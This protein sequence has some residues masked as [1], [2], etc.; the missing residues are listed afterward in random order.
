MKRG[1][2]K[3]DAIQPHPF[4][5]KSSNDG[6]FS[7]GMQNTDLLLLNFSILKILKLKI[8]LIL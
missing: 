5:V 3:R 4:P 7:Q 1:V 2:P 8:Y 6:E